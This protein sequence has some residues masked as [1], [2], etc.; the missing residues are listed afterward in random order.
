MM[1]DQF[2]Q[3]LTNSHLGVYAISA[4]PKVSQARSFVTTAAGRA[5]SGFVFIQDGRCRYHCQTSFELAGGDLAYLP[6]GSH[7]TFEVLTATVTYILINFILQDAEGR[8][9]ALTDE[10]LAVV[11]QPSAF[12]A[13]KTG[14]LVQAVRQGSLGS[15]LR[16]AAI[17]YELLAQLVQDLQAAALDRQGYAGIRPAVLYLEQHIAEEVPTAQLARLCRLSES[18]FRRIFV[19][20]KGLS[21]MA[22]RNQLRI[23][24]AR[25]LLANGAG[26]VAEIAE[27][28][29]FGD[30]FYFSAL[31]KKLT[32]HSPREIR[33]PGFPA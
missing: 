1:A 28:L 4:V 24:Q 15:E 12:Y 32:G 20:C 14:E 30:I 29:G 26:T 19:R 16:S 5:N 8:R 7:Y 33:T 6:E 31:F 2:L 27:Q 25:S 23:R 11:T 22:Y 17:L 21:P 13:L 18:Q 3:A 10:P 9:L